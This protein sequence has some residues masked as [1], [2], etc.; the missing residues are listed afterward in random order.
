MGA[1]DAKVVCLHVQ[2]LAERAAMLLSFTVA[3]IGPAPENVELFYAGFPDE[4]DC[5][6]AAG[7]LLSVG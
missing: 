7:S 4:A 1:G 6:S 2:G 5:R 3:R